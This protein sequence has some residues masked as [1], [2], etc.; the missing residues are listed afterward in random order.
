MASSN[1]PYNLQITSNQGVPSNQPYNSQFIK[2]TP[3]RG[4][5]YIN[6]TGSIRYQFSTSVTLRLGPVVKF[7]RDGYKFCTK[8][9]SNTNGD[10][11]KYPSSAT[12]HGRHASNAGSTS[13]A[14]YKSVLWQGRLCFKRE[15]EFY[16]CADK[17]SI[18]ATVE[19]CEAAKHLSVKY[20]NAAARLSATIQVQPEYAKEE[21][22]T[23]EKQEEESQTSR[24]AACATCGCTSE[25]QLRRGE[26]SNN[27]DSIPGPET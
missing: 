8:P 16:G 18:T 4:M 11:E 6:E 7:N 21:S 25:C 1:P 19:Y 17:W 22:G 12:Y 10:L 3:R 2:E 5:T 20:C 13:D 24:G 26:E 27:F 15:L 23:S 9:D 14:Y